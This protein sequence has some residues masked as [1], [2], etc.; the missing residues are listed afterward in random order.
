M[1]KPLTKYI[2]GSFGRGDKQYWLVWRL[3][4]TPIE[5]RTHRRMWDG[6]ESFDPIR[7]D[8]EAEAKAM[9]KRLEGGDQ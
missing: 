9:V 6:D 5:V 1:G 2:Q 8:T 4:Q 7:C 3:V